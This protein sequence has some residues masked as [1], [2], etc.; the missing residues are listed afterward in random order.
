MGPYMSLR[1][2]NIRV[3]DFDEKMWTV[4]VGEVSR[5]FTKEQLVSWTPVQEFVDL[6]ASYVR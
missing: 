4:A 2:S 3:T 1:I 6:C 5:R